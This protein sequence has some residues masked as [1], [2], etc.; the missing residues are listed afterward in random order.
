MDVNLLVIQDI[1][2]IQDNEMQ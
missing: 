2:C 1:V